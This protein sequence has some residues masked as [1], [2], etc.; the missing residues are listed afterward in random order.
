MILIFQWVYHYFLHAAGLR[1]NGV[2]TLFLKRED[3]I[4]LVGACEHENLTKLLI[5]DTYMGTVSCLQGKES[6]M[7]KLALVLALLFTVSCGSEEE[8]RSKEFSSKG[9]IS[10]M[11][12]VEKDSYTCNDNRYN[13]HF[14]QCESFYISSDPVQ[15]TSLSFE[16]IN[17]SVT[18][19]CI[20]TNLF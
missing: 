12:E 14:N 10:L 1:I 7:K 16:K 18:L 2:I 13:N 3:C 17:K 20:N 4:F 11:E 8:K 19:P 6:I 9:T 5:F 15:H